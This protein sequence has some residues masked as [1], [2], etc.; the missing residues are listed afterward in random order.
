MGATRELLKAISP[1]VSDDLFSRLEVEIRDLHFSWERRPPG[2]YAF[3]LLSAFDEK[4][5]SELGRRRLGELRRAVG[6]EQPPE[7]VGVVEGWVGPPIPSDAAQHMRD[8][9]WLQAMNRHAGEREDFHTLRG[10]AREQAHVLQEETKKN[11]SRF[12][13]LAVRLT[14]GINPFYSEA[15]LMGL[16]KAQPVA[17]ETVVFDAIRHI[18]SFGHKENDRWLGWALRPYLKTAPLDIVE[19][20]RDRLVVAT[21]GGVTSLNGTNMTPATAKGTS[22]CPASTRRVAPWL[23]ALQTSC[24]TMSMDRVHLS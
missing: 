24:S 6:M 17:D 8:E 7:P 19:L 11:P 1:H 23:K 13:R 10:G 5:L 15:I 2:G 4:R 3:S 9:N 21:D 16:G 12:A 18:A 22:E 14:S 20:I